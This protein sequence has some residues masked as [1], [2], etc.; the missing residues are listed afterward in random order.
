[1]HKPFGNTAK[2][3][4]TYFSVAR[5]Q[6]IET[7][8]GI[9]GQL[10]EQRENAYLLRLSRKWDNASSSLFLFSSHIKQLTNTKNKLTLMKVNGDVDAIKE[11][12]AGMAS[13]NI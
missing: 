7:T 10:S 4:Y 13:Y 11:R 1:M 3:L 6:T 8:I 12:K 9:Y 5:Y 2:C